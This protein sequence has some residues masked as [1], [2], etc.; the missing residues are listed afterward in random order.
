MDAEDKVTASSEAAKAR[1][2]RRTRRQKTKINS[3]VN[4]KD[5][6]QN[7]TFSDEGKPFE[8]SENI[9]GVNRNSEVEDLATNKTESSLSQDKTKDENSDSA[10]VSTS[11]ADCQSNIRKIKV[12]ERKRRVSDAD[13]SSSM[14][15]QNIYP[16][17]KMAREYGEGEEI[18][19][20]TQS[21]L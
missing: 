21:T 1:K 5:S 15:D 14:E 13:E 20:S 10:L 12:R 19:V 4:Q 17:T 9:G 2:K 8:T 7:S 3:E 11:E 6:T 18:K 16:A